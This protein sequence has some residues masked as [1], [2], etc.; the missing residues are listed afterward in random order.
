MLYPLYL[1]LMTRITGASFLIPFFNVLMGI[2]TSWALVQLLIKKYSL[3]NL[4]LPVLVIVLS[5]PYVDSQLLTANFLI[6]ESLSYPLFILTCY[7]TI[8]LFE[9]EFSKKYIWGVILAFSLLIF[10]RGQFAFI[11]P[12]AGLMFLHLLINKHPERYIFIGSFVAGIILMQI[13]DKSYHWIVNNRFESTS[14]GGAVMS[15]AAL[16]VSQESDTIGLYDDEKDIFK[17]ISAYLDKNHLRMRFA[18]SPAEKDIFVHYYNSFDPIIFGNSLTNNHKMTFLFRLM[19][20]NKIII[21]KSD[22]YIKINA[23]NQLLLIFDGI[24]IK[25]N[26][27]FLKY[28][29][30]DKYNKQNV[31]NFIDRRNNLSFVDANNLLFFLSLHSIKRNFKDYLLLAYYNLK[32]GHY[33]KFAHIE[34]VISIIVFF[35]SLFIYRFREN[36]K[37]CLYIAVALLL[38]ISNL[39]MISFMAIMR[40]RYIF[41]TKTL[42]LLLIFIIAGN[43]LIQLYERRKGF[44]K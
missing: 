18:E 35:I 28:L 7:Y 25:I 44:L 6:A 38:H 3:N 23:Q 17:D 15:G 5:Y 21:E 8:Q 26:R 33:S 12:V 27:T 32:C 30:S 29:Y 19:K 22:N 4:F 41:Y 36:R 16:Y 14:L 13:A 11:Y 10:T 31:Y 1:N 24:R 9:S 34:Y 39:T 43:F 40:L 20:H 2:I 37:T 42:V